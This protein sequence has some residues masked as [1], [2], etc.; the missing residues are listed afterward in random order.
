MIIQ[1]T[2]GRDLING[3]NGD[4]IIFGGGGA[5][6]LR[7]WQGF[8]VL[9]GDNGDDVLTGG[10]QNDNLFGG[11]NNDTLFGD[12]GRG[13]TK[14]SDLASDYLNGGSGN[15][16]LNQSDGND[17]F[18]FGSGSDTMVF[19]WQDP[20]VTLAVGTGRSFAN[21]IDFNPN[22]DR[23]MFDVGGLG[24]DAVGANFIDGGNGTAGGKAASFFKGATANSNG[25][26]V[27]IL[28]DKGFASGA[29]AVVQAQNEA[30]GDFIVYFNTTVN[31]ASLLYVDALDTA[32]SIA[33]FDNINSVN[34]L[35][36]TNFTDSDFLYV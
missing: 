9:S 30:T 26:S 14:G 3:G 12:N 35:S 29:D 31:V 16:R 25:E 19:K 22:E 8:D 4:D 32:H 24:S 10:V 36:N 17:T 5:D 18:A 34:E 23:F 15:D 6:N 7:G 2:N 33:R 13:T 28:T 11:A 27:M 21:L 1:G 20:M